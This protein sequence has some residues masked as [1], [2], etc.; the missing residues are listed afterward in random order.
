MMLLGIPLSGVAADVV[1]VRPGNPSLTPAAL[2]QTRATADRIE[3][4]L[5]SGGLVARQWPEASLDALAPDRTPVLI[6]ASGPLSTAGVTAMERHVAAGGRLILFSAA[7]TPSLARLLGIS[8]GEAEPERYTGMEFSDADTLRVPGLPAHV[9]QETSGVRRL[10]VADGTQALGM[11]TRGERRG[12][13]AAAIGPR[14]AYI[15]GS[16]SLG[17]PT[18]KGW[19]LHALVAAL[20]SATANTSVAALRR[21][22]TESVLATADKWAARRTAPGLESATIEAIDRELPRLRARLSALPSTVDDPARAAAVWR[23]CQDVTT[24]AQVL[25]FRMTPSPK[26]EMRGAWIHTYSPTDWDT[27]MSKLARHNFNTIFVR[28]GR[29]GNVIYPSAL[30]P[31]DAWAERAG[32]DELRR[33]I[34]AARRHGIA[35]HAW[36][37][38][39]HMGSA[40]RDHY[41]RLAAEDRLVRG[42]DG[43][44]AH[45]ANPG[46]P[47]N[48]ELEFQAMM[49]IA[50]N[51][52]VDGLHFDYIRYPDEPH[53]DFDYGSVSRREFETTSGKVVGE[54]PRDVISGP[55]KV[56]YEAWERGNISGLVERVSREVRKIRPQ[57]RLSAAVWRNH[58]YWRPIIKQ[59]W[60]LWVERGWLDFV[61]PMDYTAEQET[62]AQTVDVQVSAA[63][64][65]VPVMAGIGNYLLFTPDELVRQ[66]ESARAA[67]APGFVL[68]A[69]NA[70]QNDEHL[71]ALS[72]GAT[73]QAATSSDR[74]P[75]VRLVLP[76]ALAQRDA[77]LAIRSGTTQTVRWESSPAA[78][79][80]IVAAELAIERPEGVSLLP[81][82]TVRSGRRSAGQWSFVAPAGRWRPT[83]RG[84]WREV[85]G[86]EPT[87]FV[88]NGPVAEG[89]SAERLALIKARAEPPPAPTA[90]RG[91]AIYAYGVGADRLLGALGNTPGVV[92]YLVYRLHPEH[93]KHAAVLILPQLQDVLD[94]S[95][96]TIATL[97]N[98]VSGGGVIVLTH[99][100]VGVRW[101]P[102]LFSEIGE[103]FE[104]RNNRTLELEAA[105]ADLP[106]GRRFD[107]A[108]ADHI[109]LKL[110]PGVEVLAREP[111]PSS[112]P[113]VARG[114]FGAGTVVLMGTLPGGGGFEMAPEEQSLLRNVVGGS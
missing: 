108:F 51:Y 92:P 23:R 9:L 77:P 48:L 44:Q 80:A 22:A 70:E 15:N 18:A 40:P 107:H 67:G 34:D 49:E 64:G 61:V 17:E 35:F 12:P 6:V 38:N 99:D 4:F 60:P 86:G 55:R 104:P 100:A 97:R 24:S 1:I 90:G 71:R 101:H 66:V 45:H 114:R 5:S 72:A 105:V 54:W 95:P 111:D 8:R 63:D 46:D 93:L 13:P 73:A 29:G 10:M 113:V 2:T 36:R 50:R 65:R 33:A 74:Y 32:G 98:W 39:F 41:D 110:T 42:P 47:R 11:W 56:E 81:V 7:E 78:L 59:D 37:V 27:V 16:L 84:T 75:A 96:E 53:F 106:R 57:L 103:G 79:T 112:M 102:R 21:Q 88:L 94:L 20:D 43:K 69:Y 109:G 91:V 87:P 3:R 28:V 89:V 68:F 85:A 52:E 14:G 58:R 30:L 82:A 26:I 76:G 83:L 19:L 62:L 31:R 25:R